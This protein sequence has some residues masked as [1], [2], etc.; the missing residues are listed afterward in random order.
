M[1]GKGVEAIGF[2]RVMLA[3]AEQ[4][5]R[6]ISEDVSLLDRSSARQQGA[7][8]GALTQFELACR[9]A[10]RSAATAVDG[11]E[12]REQL[13]ALQARVQESLEVAGLGAYVA[14]AR[15]RVGMGV[16]DPLPQ[17]VESAILVPAL[18]VRM[19]G[20]P[21]SFRVA[22]LEPE[23]SSRRDLGTVSGFGSWASG[24]AAGDG[25]VAGV[26]GDAGRW[27]GDEKGTAGDVGGTC[28][29]AG[30]AGRGA[31]GGTDRPGGRTAG[32]LLGRNDSL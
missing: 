15:S 21:R 18:R 13:D 7:L 9:S 16:E 14:A 20:E 26:S 17:V 30:P 29:A 2:E 19:M 11:L 1:S 3:R 22:G 8:I 5:A 24:G 12:A 23:G 32:W 10:R 4:A 27:L 31:S 6:R 28:W 25:A